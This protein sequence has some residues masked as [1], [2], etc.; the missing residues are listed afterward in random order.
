MQT[1][2]PYP[3]YDL[4]FEN[5][6][7]AQLLADYTWMRQT[8]MV[9]A[10]TIDD[11]DMERRIMKEVD[12]GFTDTTLG[13]NFVINPPPQ[14]TRFAD[15]KSYGLVENNRGMGRYYQEAL[16]ARRQ[17]LYL[18]FGLP[19]FNSLSNFLTNFY[20]P[21][22]SSLVRTGRTPGLAY[23]I[24][25]AATF[26]VGLPLWAMSQVGDIYDFLM[27]KRSSRWYYMNPAMPLYWNAVN[28]I[29]N[30]IAVNMGI[31]PRAMTVPEQKQWKEQDSNFSEADFKKYYDVLPEIFLPTGGIDVYWINGRAQRAANRF[32]EVIN[33]ALKNNK[34]GA[35]VTSFNPQAPPK[36]V[37][38]RIKEWASTYVNPAAPTS[39]FILKM[40]TQENL[41]PAN[42]YLRA[43][44]ELQEKRINSAMEDK[45]E[46]IS[47]AF[48][49]EYSEDGNFTQKTGWQQAVDFFHGEMQD[50]SAFLGLRVDYGGTMSESWENQV[51]ESDVQS[52]LNSMS[53]T[54]RSARFT[55]AD[56]NVVGGPIGD[57]VG[58][59]TDQ[60][61]GFLGAAADTLKIGGV[62]A[63][64]GSAF[65]DI[66]KVWMSSSA[67][68]PK[69]T[70]SV[71][72]RSAY[73][74]KMSRL[75]DIYV[76]F[77]C[78]LAAG[79]PLSTGRQSYSSPFLCEAYCQGRSQTRLGMVTNISAVRG[80]GAFGWT[81]DMAPLGIDVTFE[82][83]D[84]SSVMFMPIASDYTL[85]AAAATMAAGAVGGETLQQAVQ[86]FRAATIDD[87]NTY[88]DYM[89][90]LGGLSLV[91]QTQPFRRLR[92]NI[93]R[94]MTKYRTFI[95]PSH[96]GSWAFN[97]MTGRTISM[98]YR[99]T[100]RP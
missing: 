8:F 30:G 81:R 15:I 69:E 75:L 79:M 26:V 89:A 60:V 87:D 17:T 27:G 54:A 1:H 99:G 9:P 7:M 23:K 61:K 21:V 51:G 5:T 47:N 52:K 80:T 83:Q 97:G 59:A 37:L 10:E 46:P 67:N 86:V 55:M 19:Q 35:G 71:Q 96:M 33:E 72:L 14:F 38:G 6:K 98:L 57:A 77:A 91:D 63:L 56:G 64:A 85:G 32:Q 2:S 39:Q 49:G 18:R 90:V 20:D 41:A 68:L 74:N 4:Y 95:S 93:T 73:G 3:L 44:S 16:E 88:V 11:I 62:A 78:I 43:Y 70:Y 82:V 48:G 31:V 42:A 22:A 53:A 65:V 25:R 28:T 36:T 66:P 50:G 29:V 58:W 94:E 24:G 84:L 100:D 13:G 45:F 76:P 34:L 12:F 92:L 40:N